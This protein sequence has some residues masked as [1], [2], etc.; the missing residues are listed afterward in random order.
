MANSML[1]LSSPSAESF[2]RAEITCTEEGITAYL[3]AVIWIAAESKLVILLTMYKAWYKTKCIWGTHST[4]S[5]AHP[6]SSD[7]VKLDEFGTSMRHTGVGETRKNDMNR[8]RKGL[9]QVLTRTSHE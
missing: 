9:M 2:S 3:I 4:I 5:G 7:T 6:K 8:T 1:E